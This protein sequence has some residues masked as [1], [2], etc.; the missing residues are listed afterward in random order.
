MPLKNTPTDPEYI[1]RF[2]RASRFEKEG[3][4]LH[5]L[6]VYLQLLEEF[7]EEDYTL[8]ALANLYEKLEKPELGILLLQERLKVDLENLPLRLFAGHYFFRQQAWDTT[9]EYLSAFSPAEEPLIA[10]F[11]GY[12]YYML[13]N[14]E[15]A[16]HHFKLF[17]DVNKETDFLQDAFVYLAKACVHLE[18]FNEALDYVNKAHEYYSEYYELH[19]LYAIIYYYL[20]MDYNALVAI[21]KTLKLNKTDPG[22]FDWAGKIAFRCG[23]PEKSVKYFQKYLDVGGDQS[24]EFYAHYGMSLLHN[25][26]IDQAKTH[27]ELALRFDEENALA[28]K[29]LHLIN[30]NYV[31]F[32]K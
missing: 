15:L 19:L 32:E 3:K 28:K 6:Q 22:V 31:S 8:A 21:E 14:Y 29:G 4:L 23:E 25:K 18:Q 26:K 27:F 16:K 5:A 10:F 1:H 7:P 2:D 11:V 20:E 24:A 30:T 9:I 17:L 12:S 13:K